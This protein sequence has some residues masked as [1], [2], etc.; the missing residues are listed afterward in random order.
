MRIA[1]N[2]LGRI[3]WTTLRILQDTPELELVAANDLA[4]LDNLVY[5]KRYDTVYGRNNRDVRVDGNNL[6][7]GDKS[8][9]VFSKKDLADLPWKDL[10]RRCGVSVLWLPYLVSLC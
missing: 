6:I 7:I 10:Y 4:P 9:P 5:L 3:G 8:I 2:V 1:I